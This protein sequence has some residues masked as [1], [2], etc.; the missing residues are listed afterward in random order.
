MK[1][2][3]KKNKHRK[4]KKKKEF[5]K[6]LL[7]QE[8]ILIWITTICF[9]ILAFM[10]VANHEFGDLP[11]LSV[12]SGA[13]WA[14][15]AVSQSQYYGKAKAENVLKIEKGLLEEDE[16]LGPKIEDENIEES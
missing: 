10:C 3:K 15:Y 4:N 1:P 9:L 8:S 12:M 13:P 11:W 16:D 14:A 5:S 2:F 6:S 7:I